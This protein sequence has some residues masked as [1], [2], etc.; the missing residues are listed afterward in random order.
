VTL[1]RTSVFSVTLPLCVPRNAYP[2]QRLAF[3]IRGKFVPFVLVAPKQ[4]SEGGSKV[5][6]RFSIKTARNSALS[7]RFRFEKP[8]PKARSAQPQCHIRMQFSMFNERTPDFPHPPAS[9]EKIRQA[10]PAPSVPQKYAEP[11]HIPLHSSNAV[12]SH[13]AM[14]KIP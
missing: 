14:P 7:A 13:C 1:N 2:A 6:A 10:V 4:R 3:P 12:N 9:R 5:P 11:A 8:E